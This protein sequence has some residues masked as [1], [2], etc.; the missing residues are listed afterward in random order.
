M[1]FADF[2][3]VF[4]TLERGVSVELSAG[5]RPVVRRS[6]GAA[7]A[8][9][10]VWSSGTTGEPRCSWHPWVSLKTHA[11]TNEAWAGWTWATPFRPDSFAGL[12]VALQ[13][14]ATSGQCLP[15]DGT[16]EEVWLVL[17]TRQP[18]AL[19]CTPTFL[20]LL[21]L[22]ESEAE[23]AA[24]RW[25]PQQVTLGGEPLRERTGR[26]AAKRFPNARFT[27]IYAAAEFGV[28]ARTHRTDGRMEQAAFGREG[29]D[30]R[31]RE[32]VLEV[33]RSGNWRS[34]GDRVLLE[35]DGLR[36]LGR[37]G[38]IA[39]V[40]G[41]KVRL[42]DVACAAETVPGVFQAQA[43]AEPNPVTG[44]TV[45]LRFAVEPDVDPER[46]LVQLQ[47]VLRKQLP[48]PAWPRR[49]EH[50]EA[51]IGANGKGTVRPRLYTGS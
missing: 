14:W 39:N 49:W 42:L 40:G 43:L 3:E 23:P 28:I 11:R 2:Q 12:Q 27:A 5:E 26:Q 51:V 44:Q 36:I 16:W 7:E 38:A 9:I 50:V 6:E 45:L 8:C 10:G 24:S 25:E 19:C 31:V 17:G 15:L 20:E 1:T 33:M 13:A 30:W 34:T 32:D 47:E 35:G 18:E 22:S 46:V 41:T 21:L 48:K 37:A 29:I 4:Q